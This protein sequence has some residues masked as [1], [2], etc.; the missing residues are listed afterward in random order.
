MIKFPSIFNV[1]YFV[2]RCSLFLPVVFYMMACL[3]LK[4]TD[5]PRTFKRKLRVALTKSVAVTL[6]LS[7]IYQTSDTFRDPLT[8]DRVERISALILTTGIFAAIAFLPP[9]GIQ[10]PHA[11]LDELILRNRLRGRI[12]GLNLLSPIEAGDHI[13]ALDN[14][15]LMLREG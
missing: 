2:L 11:A 14:F 3:K 7:A 10:E 13:G 5:A 6:I 15:R 9:Y 4:F 8:L 12:L 1:R